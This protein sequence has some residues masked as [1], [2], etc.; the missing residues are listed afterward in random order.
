MTVSKLL[1]VEAKHPKDFR[2][3]QTLELDQV[4]PS[5]SFLLF[6]K[7][8]RLTI[9]ASDGTEIRL[10]PKCKRC[11]CYNTIEPLIDGFCIDCY[12]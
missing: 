4:I 1:N 2:H 9:H 7:G 3:S 8:L 5:L 11:G 6:T 10:S 12:A